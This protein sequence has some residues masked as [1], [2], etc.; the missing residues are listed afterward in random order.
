MRWLQTGARSDARDLVT[1]VGWCI[2]H[3]PRTTTSH[4]GLCEEG[5]PDNQPF[6]E[7]PIEYRNF[8]Y[9]SKAAYCIVETE[10]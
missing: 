5:C 10:V 2:E 3:M 4:R 9:Q 6:R 8:P 7:V 1:A